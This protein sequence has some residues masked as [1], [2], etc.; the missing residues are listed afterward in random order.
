MKRCLTPLLLA[1]LTAGVFVGPAPA[2]PLCKEAVAEGANADGISPSP[3]DD[4]LAEARG[5]NRSIYLM[6][7]VPYLLLLSVGLLIYRSYR[8]G[9]RTAA[10]QTPTEAE[11]P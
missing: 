8:V 1:A 4:P 7:S 6:V 2:C 9:R 10:R 5:Y 3:D 11:R